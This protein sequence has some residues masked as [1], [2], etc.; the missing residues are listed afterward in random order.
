MEHELI[1]LF[2]GWGLFYFICLALS[3]A[4]MQ[5]LLVDPRFIGC[6]KYYNI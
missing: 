2:G 3:K 1:Q 6:S 4:G 5:A